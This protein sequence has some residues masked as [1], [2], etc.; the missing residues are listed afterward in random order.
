[1]GHEGDWG[2]SAERRQLLF[3]LRPVAVAL[4]L[5]GEGV[6]RHRREVDGVIA[7]APVPRRPLH[8]GDDDV[9]EQALFGQRRQAE[10]ARGRVATGGRDQLRLAQLLA[11]DLGQPVDAAAE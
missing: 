5:V 7:A 4:G 2:G 8:G 9:G 3:D 6:L 1:M 10:H 11:V